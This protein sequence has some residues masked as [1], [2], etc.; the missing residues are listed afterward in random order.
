MAA[1]RHQRRNLALAVTT[2][3]AAPASSGMVAISGSRWPRWRSMAM[4]AGCGWAMPRIMILAS[5]G[6]VGAI[7]EFRADRVNWTR[8]GKGGAASRRQRQLLLELGSAHGLSVAGRAAL[9]PARIRELAD[10]HRVEAGVAHQFLREPHRLGIVTGDRNRELRIG[11][12]RLAR[13]DRITERVERAHQPRAGQIFLRGDADSVLLDLLGDRGTVAPR[14]GVAGVEHDLVLQRVAKLL[15]EL[16]QRA[17]RH[18]DEE[19]AAEGNRLRHGAGLGERSEPAH[20]VL[21]FVGMA[22]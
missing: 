7:V 15:P 19:C 11:A 2:R 3:A 9:E 4:T 16:R 10:Q 20:H 18:R 5:A 12:V 21:K 13:E 8:Y 14:N 17:V 6:W 22:R 1:A